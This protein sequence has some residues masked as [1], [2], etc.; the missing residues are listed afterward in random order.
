MLICIYASIVIQLQW[1]GNNLQSKK[2]AVYSPQKTFSHNTC[3]RPVVLNL[4]LP[5]CSVVLHWLGET[6]NVPGTVLFQSWS[7]GQ[8]SVF[9]TIQSDDS[10]EKRWT[11]RSWKRTIAKR[12]QLCK[13]NVADGTVWLHSSFEVSWLLAVNALILL[14]RLKAQ[15]IY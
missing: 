1:I 7:V 15:L 6:W 4:S 2:T 8:T 11:W 3:A 13:P 9:Y 5:Q 12:C 14:R 10:E